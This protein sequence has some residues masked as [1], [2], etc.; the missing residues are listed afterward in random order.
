M[1]YVRNAVYLP[2]SLAAALRCAAEGAGLALGD[3]LYQALERFGRLRQEDRDSL[4][5]GWLFDM[6]SEGGPHEPFYADA[7]SL[8]RA[9]KLQ[10]AFCSPIQTCALVW[11]W[12]AEQV[13]G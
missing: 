10:V 5:R 3:Y 13:R 11:H 4:A 6:P 12:W 2:A 7:A 1:P 9:K 8:Q